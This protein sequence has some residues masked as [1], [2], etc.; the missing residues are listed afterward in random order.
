MPILRGSPHYPQANGEAE[1]AV[2]TVKNLMKKDGDPYLAILTYRSTPLKCGF[3]PSE[4]LMS[5]KLRTTLPMSRETLKP[6][7]PDPSLIREREEKLR[8][9]TQRNYDQH[10]GVRELEPLSSGQSVWIPDRGEEAQVLQE[11]GTRSY[12][13]QTSEGGVY[14]RNR[15]AL[16]DLPSS[17]S[18]ETT[19]TGTDSQEQAAETQETTHTNTQEQPRRS[20]RQSQ[21]PER[22]DTSWTTGHS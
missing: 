18:I 10:H 16:V 22:L 17:D 11:A 13:V 2:Q 5:R 20:S 7:A 8:E 4:M 21:A 9:R 15:R 1:R 19:E 14:R 6:V 12:E 3:S